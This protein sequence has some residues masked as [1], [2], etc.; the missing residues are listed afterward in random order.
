MI[1]SSQIQTNL[2]EP[3]LDSFSEESVAPV[4][5]DDL[6]HAYHWGVLRGGFDALLERQIDSL[7][8]LEQW[9]ADVGEF[10]AA[11]FEAE[12]LVEWRADTCAEY[13]EL[14]E[15]DFFIREN[16]DPL[17]KWAFNDVYLSLLASPYLGEL[18]SERYDV[19]LDYVKEQAAL[20]SMPGVTLERQM[21]WLDAGLGHWLDSVEAMV[22]EN[23]EDP[24]AEL[25]Q[26]LCSATLSHHKAAIDSL[27]TDCI[28]NRT[29][30][31][32]TV[33]VPVID[34][35]LASDGYSQVSAAQW[36]D[37]HEDYRTHMVPFAS[38]VATQLFQNGDKRGVAPCIDLEGDGVPYSQEIARYPQRVKAKA[39]EILDRI[40]PAAGSRFREMDSRGEIYLAEDPGASVDAG[41]YKFML[42]GRPRI[43]SGIL[44]VHFD[45]SDL[46]HE[47]GHALYSLAAS[48]QPVMWNRVPRHDLD[49]L[50]A[51][52]HFDIVF[53]PEEARS[54]QRELVETYVL[55]MTDWFKRSAFS[56]AI[57]EDPM[58]PVESRPE[59]WQRCLGDFTPH[60]D[61]SEYSEYAGNGYLL[62]EAVHL[63]ATYRVRYMLGTAPAIDVWLQ[64]RED[65]A[66]VVERLEKVMQAGASITPET[67]YAE[68][69]IASP[70]SIG[71]FEGF[72]KRLAAVLPELG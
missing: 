20:F 69:Q 63:S 30:A 41:A 60:A 61:W 51:S 53:D 24:H 38:S 11:Q 7:V 64:Y 12:C 33:N 10:F 4:A 23:E 70:T 9:I 42:E 56:M 26:M 54:V 18:D 17:R 67:F 19:F 40:S 14:S 34:F 15:L 45:F 5:V 57:Y 48:S 2:V 58:A 8:Q 29:K 72:S 47:A 32:D 49:E 6:T 43:V 35:I 62:D 28:Q 22:D 65:P 46:C 25:L 13:E 31:A 52:E 55:Q 71:Y 44:G 3:A 36:R 66:G 39:A 21:V 1:E 50:I 16:I 68:L 27:V 37:L 59:L